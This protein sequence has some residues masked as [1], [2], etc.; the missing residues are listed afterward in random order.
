MTT[1]PRAARDEWLEDVRRTYAEYE[2]PGGRS[3]RWQGREPGSRLS[4]LE[5]DD[6]VVS[7]LRPA[8]GGNIVDLGCGDGNLV[9]TLDRRGIRPASYL[10]IDLIE[11]RI[12]AA[13]TAT[14]WA[15]FAVASADECPVEDGWADAVVAMTL[16]SS[17]REGHFR[18]AVAREIDRITRPGG[19]L[20]VY[21]LRLPSPS[22]PHVARLTKGDVLRLFPGWKAKFRSLTLLPPL[23]RG[24][25]GGGPRRYRALGM[26]PM[27]RSHMGVILLKP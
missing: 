3:A 23:A 4:E 22:N 16:F 1:D 20:V 18:A 5:R 15:H 27:L 26:L 14:P 21:D 10:G 9:R 2:S 13:R 7:A 8:A 11:G 25:F 19:R 17:I 12:A 24:P 6:W